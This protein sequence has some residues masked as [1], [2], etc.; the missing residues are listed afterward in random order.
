MVKAVRGA[1]SLNV[2]TE[3]ELREKVCLLYDELTGKNGIRPSRII[4]IVFSQTGDIGFNPAKA[5]RI[6]RKL[7]K[8]PLFCT[9][10][11]VCEDF[12]HPMMLRMLLSYRSPFWRRVSPVYLGRAS[13]LRSDGGID[14]GSGPD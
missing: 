11:P 5:L 6:G 3:E 9:Q 10:E 7:E 2:D 8:A 13:Q 12:P 4:S 14:T 1:V